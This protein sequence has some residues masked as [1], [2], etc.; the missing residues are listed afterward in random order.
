MENRDKKLVNLIGLSEELQLPIDWL[1]VQAESGRIPC[2]FIS[3]KK[4]RFNPE[5][6]EKALADLAAKGGNNDQ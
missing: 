4:M 1:R 5:A 3:R 6:V 2:L